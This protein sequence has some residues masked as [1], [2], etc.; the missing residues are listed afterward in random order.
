[1]PKRKHKELYTQREKYKHSDEWERSQIEERN[2][3][4]SKGRGR[5]KQKNELI[6]QARKEGRKEGRKTEINKKRKKTKKKKPFG[7]LSRC[8]VLYVPSVFCSSAGSWHSGYVLRVHLH[9]TAAFGVL[10]AK[11]NNY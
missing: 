7:Q 2:R 4:G 9:L 6:K 8:S 1:V 10:T 11:T 3:N 5:K